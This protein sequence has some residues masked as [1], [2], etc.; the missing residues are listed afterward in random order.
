MSCCFVCSV[1]LIKICDR[2]GRTF[3]ISFFLIL[4]YF[5]FYL[6]LSLFLF[7][8]LLKY[9]KSIKSSFLIFR[10]LLENFYALIYFFL[11]P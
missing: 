5:F 7:Q 1:I 4:F 8:E 3:T 9:C 10:L 6:F 2:K 11:R